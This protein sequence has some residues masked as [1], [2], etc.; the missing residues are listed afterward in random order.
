VKCIK[1]TGE[2]CQR[3]QK[4]AFDCHSE[5]NKRGRKPKSKVAADDRVKKSRTGNSDL[6][7]VPTI[8]SDV[9]LQRSVWHAL[10]SAS[11]ARGST[12]T[13]VAA[14]NA[15]IAADQDRQNGAIPEQSSPPLSLRH[16]LQRVDGRPASFTSSAAPSLPRSMH[17][18]AP[19]D[20]RAAGIVTQ[21]RALHLLAYFNEHLAPW[22]AALDPNFDITCHSF[23]YSTILY[24]ASKYCNT[25]L[26]ET[27]ALGSHTRMLA[28]LTFA[29]VDV[30]PGSI[31]A[32]HLFTAW[33]DPDDSTSEVYTSYADRVRFIETSK[34][35]RHCERILFFHYV[36]QSVFLLHYRSSSLLNKNNK[37]ARRTLSWTQDPEALIGD[38]FLCSDVE[39]TAIQCKYKVLFE[40]QHQQ[41]MSGICGSANSSSLLDAFMADI[42][43]WEHRWKSE[44][45]RNDSRDSNFEMR[46][47][48]FNLFRNSVCTQI[49]SIALYQALQFWIKEESMMSSTFL[50]K[51]FKF[52]LDSCLALLDTS[53]DNTGI[54][55]HMPDSLMVLFDQAAL[56][57]TYLLLLP[58]MM[59]KSSGKNANVLDSMKG[60]SNSIALDCISKIKRVEILLRTAFSTRSSGLVTAVHLS[61]DYLASLI[62]LVEGHA[63]QGQEDMQPSHTAAASSSFITALDP[64]SSFEETLFTPEWLCSFSNFPSA[65]MFS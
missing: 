55:L 28:V 63:S 56:L 17:L 54:I 26:E 12:Y 31:L 53:T 29:E 46:M 39:S 4:Y 59:K 20:P 62:T 21:S 36:Q 52:C 13:F 16:L 9:G 43:D 34:R 10:T 51:S 37:L 18:D 64:F 50:E 33:K 30:R 14:G 57:V 27:S 7:D 19:R 35:S 47:L 6:I 48:G 58:T 11:A 2:D 61:A 23:L 44:A 22:I 1:P 5:I 40:E 45:S 49:A 32:Y 42:G 15:D 8:L 60:F 41:Y 65:N 24:Q 3:C 25:S 38:W